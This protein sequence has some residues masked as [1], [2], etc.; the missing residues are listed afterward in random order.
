MWGDPTGHFH[1]QYGVGQ[2][3]IQN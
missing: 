2:K 1:A 3:I